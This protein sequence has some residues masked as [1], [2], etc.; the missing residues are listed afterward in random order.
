MQGHCRVAI[1]ARAIG[2]IRRRKRDRHRVADGEAE[3]K[4]SEVVRSRPGR[5]LILRR[6]FVNQRTA[7]ESA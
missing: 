2:V 3:T 4:A 5:L 6:V 7:W 1:S